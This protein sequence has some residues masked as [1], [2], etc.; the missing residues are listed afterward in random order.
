MDS[1]KLNVWVTQAGWSGEIMYSIKS[2]KKLL[3]ILPLP[4]MQPTGEENVPGLFYHRVASNRHYRTDRVYVKHPP[5]RQTGLY[6]KT[7]FQNPINLLS[8]IPSASEKTTKTCLKRIHPWLHQ[9]YHHLPE[10]VLCFSDQSPGS[11]CWHP[12]DAVSSVL[13]PPR[14]SPLCPHKPILHWM[15]INLGT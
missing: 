3:G 12:F 7:L 4:H 15:S 14:L 2:D 8:A 13:F 5:F 1:A 10:V 11:V 9:T 6:F